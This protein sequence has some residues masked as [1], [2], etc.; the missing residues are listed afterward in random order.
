MTKPHLVDFA[1]ERWGEDVVK[2]LKNINTGGKNN[3]KGN[4]YE[5]TYLVFLLA[6]YGAEESSTTTF[7]SSQEEGYVDDITLRI[8]ASRKINYQA[9]NSSGAA[10]DW[11]DSMEERFTKQQEIDIEYHG[12]ENPEQVLLVSCDDK[13]EKNSQKIEE[14]TL[15]Y[16][17]C[18][19]YPY[20]EQP[21]ELLLTHQETRRAFKRICDA[22]FLDVQSNAMTILLGVLQAKDISKPVAVSTLM[23]E[24]KMASKPNIFNGLSEEVAAEVSID[25]LRELI[26]HFPYATI[27]VQSGGYLV[28]LRGMGVFLPDTLGAEDGPSEPVDDELKLL[29]FLFALSSKADLS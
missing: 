26:E 5:L 27:N 21:L 9:K 8:G 10:A 2:Q 17:S 1:R 29:E 12:F 20:G 19:F 16:A 25:W 11:T 7:L 24:A 13:R 28:S 6:K 4:K 14:S 22:D 3:A 15:D 23:T 18:Q